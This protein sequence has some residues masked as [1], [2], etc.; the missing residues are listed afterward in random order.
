MKAKDL[1]RILQVCNPEAEITIKWKGDSQSDIDYRKACCWLV[2]NDDTPVGKGL[3][4][5]KSFS[6]VGAV[7]NESENSQSLY[8]LECALV[9]DQE[10]Y[11]ESYIYEKAEELKNNKNNEY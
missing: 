3:D 6:V 2:L 7:F 4:A 8:N 1:I 5:L 10:Y 9:I 11:V